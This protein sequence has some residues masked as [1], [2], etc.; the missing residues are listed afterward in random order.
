MGRMSRT[1]E[2]LR[3]GVL[4]VIL[5]WV[6]AC[7][8]HSAQD[9]L[10]W[11]RAVESSR[12]VV[13]RLSVDQAWQECKP[14]AGSTLIPSVSCGTS[15]GGDEQQRQKIARTIAS[16]RA[17]VTP[18]ANP[19][20]LHAIA[21]AHLIAT[22]PS[23]L[24]ADQAVSRLE[25]A[26]LS[27]G[28][29]DAALLSD[30]A[31]AYL[32]RSQ[33]RDDPEDLFRALDAVESAYGLA[34]QL[35]PVLFNRALT[36][37]YLELRRQA[38]VAWQEYLSIDVD[39]PW[40]DEARDRL[41]ML[42]TPTP[43]DF[44]PAREENLRRAL[45]GTWTGPAISEI[46][47]AHPQ[48]VRKFLEEE[49]LGQWGEAVEAGDESQV[50]AL[51][52]LRFASLELAQ[53]QGDDLL[54]KSV[55]RLEDPDAY[56]ELAIAHRLYRKARHLYVEY[57]YDE[58]DAMFSESA[59]LLERH[60]S[61]FAF[62]PLF[63]R[64]AIVHHKPDFDRSFQLFRE[65]DH[66]TRFDHRLAHA[67]TAWMFGLNHFRRGEFAPAGAEF[68]HAHALFDRLGEIENRAAMEIQLAWVEDE[69]GESGE[70]WRL[71][72]RALKALDR[73]VT[74]RRTVNCLSTI[75]RRL[76]AA[77]LHGAALHFHTAHARSAD[78]SEDKLS[79]TFAHAER[80]AVLLELGRYSDAASDLRVAERTV[81]GIPDEGLRSDASAEVA[82]IRAKHFVAESPQRAIPVLDR[83][84]DFAV[85]HGEGRMLIDQHRERGHA[86]VELGDVAGAELEL[87]A[88]L[89]EVE[90]Q[91]NR[92]D[93]PFQ[94]RAYLDQARAVAEELVAHLFDHGETTTAL[95]V[96]ERIRAP[97]LREQFDRSF[98]AA[99][100]RS[101]VQMMAELPSGT[102]ILA[103]LA[104]D[105]RVLGWLI[106]RE[107]LT[108][109]VLELNKRSLDTA[110]SRWVAKLRG[111][112]PGVALPEPPIEFLPSGDVDW[113]AI[114]S[115]V[116]VPDGVLYQLPFAALPDVVAEGL[117]IEHRA[118]SIAP[119]VNL[120]LDI[121]RRSAE[122]SRQ[123]LESLLIVTEL[124]VS[125]RF[126]DLTP[127][128]PRG[129]LRAALDLFPVV[130]VLRGEAATEEAILERLGR[131]DVVEFGGHALFSDKPRS[132]PT[133]GLVVAESSE[134]DGWLT[135][136]EML[137]D[138]DIRTRVVVLG[139]C[140]TAAGRL[141]PT[142]GT[143][144]LARP[145]LLA[146]VDSVVTTL[147][148]LTDDDANELVALMRTFLTDS[149]PAALRRAQVELL[150]RSRPSG[151]GSHAWAGFV[152]WGEPR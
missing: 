28:P 90:R 30:L 126:P 139:G 64:A 4:A 53:R 57:H 138:T 100:T 120:Y 76:V 80:A 16:L 117:L 45:L 2:V 149:E 152:T 44:W 130:E 94:R 142:E 5:L 98:G 48:Q 109:F 89:R 102:A 151:V 143:L 140:R 79:I 114:K 115:L 60:R 6:L 43:A 56:P 113:A 67:F 14:T 72:F 134:E 7:G 103:Y 105:E 78:R 121:V 61:P 85:R 66:D 127:L 84:R 3:H 50:S 46:I 27:G 123:P 122:R 70:S 33:L 15:R 22:A 116:I 9:S 96:Y 135:P 29:P 68:L 136:D 104:L 82:L 145:L 13:P 21:L 124:P 11:L 128:R 101:L 71:L 52:F 74:P 86:L 17:S 133:I 36:L 92:L 40:S 146:G 131:Y 147:W 59:A 65:I 150:R 62:W 111:T 24:S 88:A 69:I 18:D 54:A 87:Y 1:P 23:P 63:Y 144:G 99:S 95:E 93:D 32:V 39:S 141:S 97:V 41:A 31:A 51:A 19:A 49:A 129:D 8:G 75:A 119:S 38:I 10:A 25:E 47:A 35:P 81:Q 83:V 12:T 26:R 77:K 34:P 132:A 106:Q 73:T 58:A 37:S 118:M 42:A 20:T 107:A 125:S 112:R 137:L 108:P 55:A 91:R 110:V 148:P